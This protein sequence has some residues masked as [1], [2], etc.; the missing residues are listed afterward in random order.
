MLWLL[1]TRNNTWW[2]LVLI[3]KCFTTP[4]LRALE[5]DLKEIKISPI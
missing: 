1:V 4:R 2:K 5:D 3:E